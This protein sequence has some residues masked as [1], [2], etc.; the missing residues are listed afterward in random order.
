MQRQGQEICWDSDFTEETYQDRID[1]FAERIFG[2]RKKHT[3]LPNRFDRE[4]YMAFIHS[5]L[6]RKINAEIV[7]LKERK[8]E[9]ISNLYRALPTGERHEWFELEDGMVVRIRQE[10]LNS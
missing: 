2:K 6:Y 7:A 1:V 10:Y 3:R 9:L 4:E 8:R 5:E